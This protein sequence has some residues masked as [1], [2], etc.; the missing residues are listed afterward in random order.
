MSNTRKVKQRSI[1]DWARIAKGL[2]HDK[3][4]RA[5]LALYVNADQRNVRLFTRDMM[6]HIQ[7]EVNEFVGTPAER[8]AFIASAWQTVRSMTAAEAEVIKANATLVMSTEKTPESMMR[9]QRAEEP[10]EP[11]Y[12]GPALPEG[13]AP[14][15]AKQ[16]PVDPQSKSPP[17]AEAPT[18]S[19]G[20]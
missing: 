14:V 12:S 17:P 11:P 19:A 9:P 4:T 10:E 18:K 15:K 5:A 6:R 2:A 3:T 7:E 16:I 20:S 1:G 8:V 13:F